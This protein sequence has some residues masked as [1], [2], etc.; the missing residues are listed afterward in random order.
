MIDISFVLPNAQTFYPNMV[1]GSWFHHSA[2]DI[3][4]PFS[5]TKPVLMSGLFL[6]ACRS[7][8]LLYQQDNFDYHALRYRN[9]CLRAVTHDIGEGLS[10]TTVISALH[11]G[12]DE[13]NLYL[14]SAR[15]QEN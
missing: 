10:D 7:L 9:D 2:R 6:T 11:L 8:A 4:V 14:H 13:V 15:F 3:L 12:I 1:A 5:F